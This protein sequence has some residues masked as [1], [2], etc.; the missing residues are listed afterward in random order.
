VRCV[1]QMRSER[2]ARLASAMLQ[3]GAE[4]MKMHHDDALRRNR[5]AKGSGL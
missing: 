3:R 4:P 5:R 1:R 2:Q